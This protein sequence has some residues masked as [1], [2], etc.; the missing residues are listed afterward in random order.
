MKTL[1][2]EEPINDLSILTETEN[3]VF[4][5]L[6]SRWAT[7]RCKY[8]SGISYKQHDDFRL[9]LDEAIEECAD[10]LQYL[11]AMKLSF[12]KEIDND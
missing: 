2:G 5:I 9:W 10:Q 1:H 11:V 6:R 12:E 4:D 3:A 7:G 8:D